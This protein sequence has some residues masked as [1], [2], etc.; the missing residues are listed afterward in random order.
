[1]KISIITVTYNALK[2]LP[3]LVQSLLSQSSQEFEWVIVD[4]LSEDGTFEYISNIEKI[5]IKILSEKDFGIYDALN[6]AVNICDND[7]YLVVGAD[8]Y[9]YEDAVDNYIKAILSSDA[10]VV[11]SSIIVNGQIVKKKFGWPVLNNQ[12]AFV[13]GHAVGTVYN[14]SL[15]KRFGFYSNRFPIAA[16]H[17]FIKKLAEG[18]AYIFES[19]FISGEFGTSGVSSSDLLGALSENFRIQMESNKS[20]FTVFLYIVRLVKNYHK[21]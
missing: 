13:S 16:D 7:Y 2:H 17:L 21:F 8:D 20:M 11:T 18:G 15:H 3:R 5:D 9:L 14:K 10:D 1:M 4:G 19:D 6:K 12:N